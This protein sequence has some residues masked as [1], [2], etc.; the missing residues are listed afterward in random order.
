[1]HPALR[2]SDDH[3]SIGA[4]GGVM[5]PASLRSAGEAELP[6]VGAC[7]RTP[8]RP[9]GRSWFARRT[10]RT[11]SL[12]RCLS[13]GVWVQAAQIRVEL[14]CVYAGQRSGVSTKCPHIL[15]YNQ[16][17]DVKNIAFIMDKREHIS[18]SPPIEI[19]GTFSR[20]TVPIAEFVSMNRMPDMASGQPPSQIGTWI[21]GRVRLS[22]ARCR[23]RSRV[24]G[25]HARQ[26]R[27]SQ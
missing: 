15:A 24:S 13:N 6:G 10:A 25:G 2:A 21:Q 4:A 18:L 26:F 7:V 9:A 17:D 5:N 12:R 20:Q 1:M 3:H 16:N 22:R 23:A 8:E 19:L 14:K 27:W 11:P